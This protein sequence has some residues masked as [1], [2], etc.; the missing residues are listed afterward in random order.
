VNFSVSPVHTT[1][2][3]DLMERFAASRFRDDHLVTRR[4]V[5]DAH[6]VIRRCATRVITDWR[7]LSTNRTL[8][9]LSTT[10]SASKRV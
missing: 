3:A 1:I 2:Y 6:A 10:S 7:A 9:L 5:G 4:C 8:W